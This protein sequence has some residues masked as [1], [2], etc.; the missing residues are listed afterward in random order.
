[1]TF[2]HR[3]EWGIIKNKSA[4]WI[5]GEKCVPGKGDNTDRD[6]NQ[7]ASFVYLRESEVQCGAGDRVVRDE[8]RKIIQIPLDCLAAACNTD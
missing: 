7:G 5:T 3:L 8:V 6:S 2:E 1:M 4:T